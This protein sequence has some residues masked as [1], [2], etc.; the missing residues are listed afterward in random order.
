MESTSARLCLPQ[1]DRGSLGGSLPVPSLGHF[2]VYPSRK[3][4]TFHIFVFILFKIGLFQGLQGEG[5][6]IPKCLAHEHTVH[7]E[8]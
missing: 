5:R 6:K 1:A 2:R 3:W 7:C 4:P 8:H